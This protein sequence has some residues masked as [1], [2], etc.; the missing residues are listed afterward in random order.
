MKTLVRL[1][2]WVG[3]TLLALPAIEGL[4]AVHG[5]DLILIGRALPLEI[6]A[7]LVPGARRVLLRRGSDRGVS[8]L[9]A[10]RALRRLRAEQA[11]LMTPSFSAALM[12]WAAGIPVR[13]GWDE[14]GRGLFLTTR[15]PRR[16]RGE[17]H[18]GREYGTLARAA[19]ARSFPPRPLLPPDEAAAESAEHFLS[20]HPVQP[21]VALCPGVQ[22]GSA[23]R[24][25]PEHFM[26]L[27]RRL[28]GR[29]IAGL[30]VG[31]TGERALGATILADTGGGWINGAGS[32]NLRHSA[33]LLRR[34]RVAVCNDT[35]TMHLAAAVG[36]PVVALIGPSDPAWTGPQGGADRIM[37]T[38]RPC[39]PCFKRHCPDGRP[40]PCMLE[41]SPEHVE[42]EVMAILEGDAGR[43]AAL[44]L[45]RDGTL[46]EPVSYLHDPAQVRLVSGAG[47]ALRRAREAGYA[48]VVV[49]NQSGLARSLFSAREMEAVHAAIQ[50]ALAEADV[51]IDAFYHCP[52]HPDFTGPCTCR[53][54]APGM[55][56]L[57]AEQLRLDL[58][59]SVMIGDTWEDV[60]AGER[61][62]CRSILIKTGYGA[63]V[64][65]ARGAEIP[66]HVRIAA[67]L[68]A[69][70]DNLLES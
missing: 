50:D 21:L 51:A 64:L 18:I 53:K 6:V 49:T 54:P 29:G 12:V 2:N 62:G 39:A 37:R 60:I 28:E 65:A 66:A 58:T 10:V 57:A 14:Q 63:Q 52:H 35:G 19:G 26:A 56:T 55:L 22:Y 61:A 25:P 47:G 46:V 67:N 5:E 23:K 33:E 68:P 16:P 40:S 31:A 24:W 9:A 69:A 11:L 45:D 32:G 27:R 43:R 34:M 38:A 41:L 30:I 4:A 13:A 48:L 8:G 15:I 20:T 17:E 42:R 7:H 70:I 44:F 1:P 36:C 59:R 3:D